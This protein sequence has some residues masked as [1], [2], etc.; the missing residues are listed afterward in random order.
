MIEGVKGTKPLT[1]FCLVT[2]QWFPRIGTPRAVAYLYKILFTKTVVHGRFPGF[3]THFRPFL[4]T[5]CAKNDGRQV[6]FHRRKGLTALQKRKKRRVF[7][8]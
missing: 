8:D 2:T 6:A 7:D 4:E 3:P 1:P 5:V